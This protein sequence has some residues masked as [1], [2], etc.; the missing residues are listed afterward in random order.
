M[1]VH[2]RQ[3]VSVMGLSRQPG[4]GIVQ[5]RR[6]PTVLG[7]LQ[8]GALPRPAGI[9]RKRR[10]PHVAGGQEKVGKVST[11]TVKTTRVA[12]FRFYLFPFSDDFS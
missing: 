7:I 12:Y 3:R 1:D 2:Q 4:Q 8:S 11:E 6:K 5:F 10:H 9:P